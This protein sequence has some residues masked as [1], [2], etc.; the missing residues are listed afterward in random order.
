MKDEKKVEE[1]PDNIS[2]CTICGCK[3]N[4]DTETKWSLE[5]EPYCKECAIEWN[6]N[7]GMLYEK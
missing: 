7:S 5:A 6:V 1:L 4:D 3:T 2:I